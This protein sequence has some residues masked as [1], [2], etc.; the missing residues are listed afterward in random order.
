MQA[1]RSALAAAALL[2]MP[3]TAAADIVGF[4]FGAYG[5]EASPEGYVEDTDGALGSR[6]RADL[7]N[8]LRLGEETFGVIWAA[9]E[10]PLPVLPNLKL[11]YTPLSFEGSG[12]VDTT[13]N[14][15]GIEFSGTQNVD[16][17]LSL[18]QLDTILYYEVLDGTFNLDAGLNIKLLDGEAIFTNR[19][20]GQT[21][22]EE[23][24]APVPMLYLN[25]SIELPAG[26]R[27]G[28]EGS[29]VAYSG[30]RLTDIKALVGWEY[31]VVSIEA[32]YRMQQLVLDDIEGI[33]ADIEIGGPFLGASVDF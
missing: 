2:G 4:S 20:T 9:I 6:S 30:N 16:S 31:A 29:G 10:H 1:F 25:A 7:E 32:G 23:F 12:E 17:E 8:D 3:L 22:T 5:W 33:N 18:N 26:F 21:A 27:I 14:F 24:K 28:L 15:Q 13:F 19:D 11:Q